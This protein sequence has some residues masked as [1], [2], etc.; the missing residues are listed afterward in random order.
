MER[1]QLRIDPP[2]DHPAL[3]EAA[4]R[5]SRPQIPSVPSAGGD[6]R[7]RQGGQAVGAAPEVHRLR[8]DQNPHA[9][10]NRDHVAAFTTRS[11][12]GSVAA[13]VPGATQTVAAP[14]TISIAAVPPL[15][16]GP[17]RGRR[18]LKGFL[19]NDRGEGRPARSH[20]VVRSPSPRPPLRFAP[21]TKQLLRRQRRRATAQTFSPLP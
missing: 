4:T 10:R 14:I 16:A 19:D 21:P 18:S 7:P 9:R 15:G 8:G 6:P 1:D 20:L 13:S 3:E 2:V 5:N 17:N 11:T 12:V